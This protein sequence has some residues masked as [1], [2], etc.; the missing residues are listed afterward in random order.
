M[1]YALNSGF[2]PKVT[3]ADAHERPCWRYHQNF[4][5]FVITFFRGVITKIGAA[6]DSPAALRRRSGGW[7]QTGVNRTS[8]DGQTG[9]S[10]Q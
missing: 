1:L 9:T 7:D 3:G 10:A 6:G 4:F 2:L 5:E 8:D